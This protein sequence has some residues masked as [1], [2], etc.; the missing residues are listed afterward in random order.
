MFKRAHMA[1]NHC[2]LL[3]LASWL[4]VALAFSR[5]Q[6]AALA[7]HAL[8]DI[9]L[10]LLTLTSVVGWGQGSLTSSIT[11]VIDLVG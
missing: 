5:V 11:C 9:P 10:V 8:K 1:L 3:T 4:V 7:T 6:P 2:A